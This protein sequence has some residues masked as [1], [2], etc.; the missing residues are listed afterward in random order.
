VSPLQ[1]IVTVVIAGGM[2]GAAPTRNPEVPCPTECLYTLKAC[3]GSVE[4]D[5]K[6]VENCT[7]LCRMVPP[8]RF[9][10]CIDR[11]AHCGGLFPCI[12]GK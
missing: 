5:V 6:L 8:R 11:P 2:S 9:Y 12:Q 4:P 10:K 1:L 3:F 7:S